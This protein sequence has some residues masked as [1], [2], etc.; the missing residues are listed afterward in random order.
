MK[1]ILVIFLSIFAISSLISAIFSGGVL[2][3]LK[4]KQKGNWIVLSGRVRKILKDKER[5]L[6]KS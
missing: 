1:I 6:W 2:K 5:D 4:E 3:R